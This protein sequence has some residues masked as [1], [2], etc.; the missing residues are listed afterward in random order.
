[1]GPRP[2]AE[3]CK[4]KGGVREHVAEKCT[5]MVVVATRKTYFHQNS[6]PDHLFSDT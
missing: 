4:A 3:K 2:L 5:A 6:D 1:M